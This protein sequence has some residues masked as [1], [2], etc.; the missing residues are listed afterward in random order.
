M[1]RRGI[2]GA[3]LILSYGACG[4]DVDDRPATYAYIG[5]DNVNAPVDHGCVFTAKK[6]PSDGETHFDSC[7]TCHRQAPFQGVWFDLGE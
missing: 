1:V 4:S 5:D 3:L 7:W 6:S 2:A